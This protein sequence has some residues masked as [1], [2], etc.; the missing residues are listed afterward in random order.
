MSAP[1]EV[2]QTNG[3]GSSCRTRLCSHLFAVFT[4]AIQDWMKGRCGKREDIN[5]ILRTERRRLAAARP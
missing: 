1:A 2:M 3:F 5:G 4:V